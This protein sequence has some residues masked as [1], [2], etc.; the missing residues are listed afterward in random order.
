MITNQ[1][2]IGIGSP[3]GDDQAGWKVIEY[4]E[5]GVLPGSLNILK[6]DRPGPELINHL[7]GF[8]R[9]TLIDALLDQKA[10]AGKTLELS[11]EHLEQLTAASTHGFGLAQTLALA[12]ALGQ[13][14]EDL[15]IFAITG[16]RFQPNDCLN[17]TVKTA[18][19]E[20]AQR[21]VDEHQTAI[22]KGGVGSLGSSSSS[23]SPS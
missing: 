8:D 20:L 1:L 7:K 5:E 11:L 9:V 22:G 6:L 15:R 13:L 12:K 14:P 3:F 4:L 10:D 2:V 21:L 23:S 18:A 16:T 19:Q 17:P